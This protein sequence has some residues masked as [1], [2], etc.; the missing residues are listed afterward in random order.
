MIDQAF[1]LI[2][3]NKE[4]LFSGVGIVIVGVILRVFFKTKPGSNQTIK[5]GKNSKNIQAGRDIHIGDE[6]K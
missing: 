1:E 5:S 3:N 6:R 4:W 2:L